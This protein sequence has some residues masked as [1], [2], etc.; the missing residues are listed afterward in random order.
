MSWLRNED[1][2]AAIVASILTAETILRLR[3]WLEENSKR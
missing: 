1:T 2:D 3:K